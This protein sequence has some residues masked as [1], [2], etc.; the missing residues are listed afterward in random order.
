M[1]SIFLPFF[2][3]FLHTHFKISS[4][5][6]ILDPNLLKSNELDPIVK[7]VCSGKIGEYAEDEMMMESESSR[8]VLM[9]QK[10]YISYETL[11]RDLVPC[12]TPGASYY[13]CNGKGVASPYNRGC[14]VITRCARDA[15][16]T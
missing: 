4:G 13:N 7:R 2:F 10:K 3:I 9:V 14:E 15:M 16:N 5:V 8:R 12:G 6:S 1:K 11:K